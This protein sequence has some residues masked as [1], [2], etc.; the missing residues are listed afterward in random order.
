MN[1]LKNN[2]SD[3]LLLKRACDLA[4]LGEGK[5]SPNPLVGAVIA[6]DGK[7]IGEGWHNQYGQAHAE[8]NAVK[9]ALQHSIPTFEETQ[10]FVTLEPCTFHGKTPACTDLI[11]EKKIPSIVIGGYDSTPQVFQKSEKILNEHQIQ[12]SYLDSL[13]E[14]RMLNKY[15]KVNTLYQ[16]PYIILK[17]AQSADGFIGKENNR[18]KISNP[19]TDRLVHR[20]RAECD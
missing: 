7:V 11:I 3:Q 1:T 13:H 20:W 16:R 6:K 4:K 17:Y 19:Y 15:R 18:T 2:L 12:V 10:L 8:V 9:D 14:T 5:V